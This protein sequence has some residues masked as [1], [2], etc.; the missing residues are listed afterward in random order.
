MISNLT[1]GLINPVIT[2]S[3]LYS[4]TSQLWG[5]KS[6]GWFCLVLGAQYSQ[7][8]RLSLKETYGNNGKGDGIGLVKRCFI[9]AEI[10]SPVH[11]V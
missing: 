6:C 8:L 11:I 4:E 9:I 2:K 10:L 7:F 3:T 1:Y 5:E